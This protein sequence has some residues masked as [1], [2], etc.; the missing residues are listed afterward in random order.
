MVPVFGKYPTSASTSF[1]PLATADLC[2][3]QTKLGFYC[4]QPHIMKVRRILSPSLILPVSEEAPLTFHY[5]YY[6]ILITVTIATLG[7]TT[8]YRSSL[9]EKNAGPAEELPKSNC[10]V[11]EGRYSLGL[12]TESKMA[13]HRLGASLQNCPLPLE[14]IFLK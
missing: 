6:I 13:S 2:F 7:R 8:K 1:S 10:G 11:K 4:F 9:W 5:C 14:Y 12:A 3:Y